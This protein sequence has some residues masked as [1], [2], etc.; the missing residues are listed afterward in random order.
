MK[1]KVLASLS[2]A[3]AMVATTMP[4]MAYTNS[5][6]AVNETQEVSENK[7]AECE[8]YAEIGSTFTVTIPKKITL[9][10]AT[11][12]GAYTVACT[13]DI[14]GDEYVSVVPDASFDMIQTGKTNVTASVTQETQNFR[15]N[16]YTGSVGTGEAKM[17]DGATGSISAAGLTAGAWKGTFNFTI[18]LKQSGT[19]EEV[20]QASFTI[21]GKSFQVDDS[22]TFSEWVSSDYNTDGYIDAG[23]GITTASGTQCVAYQDGSYYIPVTSDTTIDTS[24][25]YVL[26]DNE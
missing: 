7:E 1:K 9:A 4:A 19:T 12:T 25:N 11:K 24:V 6:G 20:S 23:Y 10:G 18:S 22:M 16:N 3:A 26:V 8:V 5:V 21:D 17:E 13:G 14:A 15:G 2:L